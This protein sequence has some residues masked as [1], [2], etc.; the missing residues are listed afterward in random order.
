MSKK[1]SEAESGISVVIPVKNESAGLAACLTGILEQTEPVREI[2]VIDSG[3]TDGTQEIARSFDKVRLIEIKPNDFNHGDTRNLGVGEAQGEFVIMTVG[4]AR[5]VD[6]KWLSELLAGFVAEDVVAVAGSQVV[7]ES[8]NTNP[9]EWFRP[10]SRPE[11]RVSR[12]KT[13]DAFEAADPLEKWQATSLDDVTAAYRRS[14]LTKQPFRRVVYGEDTFFALDA[15]KSEKAIAFNPAARVYHY[16]LENYATVH[17]R[18][19]AVASLRYQM[20]GYETTKHDFWPVYLRGLVRLVRN[21][22]LTWV[23]RLR[24]ARYNWNLG[25]ALSDGIDKV[26]AARAKGGNAMQDLHEEYCGTPPMPLKPAMAPKGH[27]NQ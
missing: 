27:V 16:H 1:I 26:H 19:I 13:P 23:E 10:R 20:T 9:L 22:K 3:S 15:L 18:T 17:K 2:I 21:P 24:W 5:P 14:A 8:K 25:K 6:S 4:D 11:I 12:Y 7:P